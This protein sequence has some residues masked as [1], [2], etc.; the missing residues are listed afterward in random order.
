DVYKRQEESCTVRVRMI[1]DEGERVDGVRVELG[2]AGEGEQRERCARSMVVRRGAAIFTNAPVV[3]GRATVRVVL[4]DGSV[5]EEVNAT[6]GPK[7]ST[8]IILSASGSLR[9][10]MGP[11]TGGSLGVR[12]WR[13]MLASP[14]RGTRGG[15]AGMFDWGTLQTAWFERVRAGRVT[16]GVL[17]N[18]VSVMQTSVVIRAGRATEVDAAPRW[19]MRL[20]TGWLRDERGKEVRGAISVRGPNDRKARMYGEYVGLYS[21]QPFQAGSDYVIRY[22]VR[23]AK[24]KVRALGAGTS[25]C[26]VTVPQARGVRV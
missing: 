2:V 21:I 15:V 24:I 22:R 8:A 4:S 5:S 10:V 9:V 26:N 18:E 3:V 19:A 17:Y 16:L 7:A 11:G 20:V 13:V 1:T 12:T 14:E 25:E 23:T 6:A